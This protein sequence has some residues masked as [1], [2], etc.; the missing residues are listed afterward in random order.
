MNKAPIKWYHHPHVDLLK[1]FL[2]PR[3]EKNSKKNSKYLQMHGFWYLKANTINILISYD[4]H[5]LG[6]AYF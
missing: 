3:K 4:L 6:I 1:H 2:H 5:F